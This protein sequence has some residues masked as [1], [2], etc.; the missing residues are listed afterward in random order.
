MVTVNDPEWIPLRSGTDLT[1]STK[2]R[3]N[4]QVEKGIDDIYVTQNYSNTEK[5]LG[6]LKCRRIT[7]HTSPFQEQFSSCLSAFTC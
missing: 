5:T 1:A 2:L 7:L 3:V 6:C 4:F